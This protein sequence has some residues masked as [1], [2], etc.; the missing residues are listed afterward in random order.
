MG[1]R[2]S[3]ALPDFLQHRHGG[4]PVQ[5]SPYKWKQYK[6]GAKIRPAL[7]EIMEKEGVVGPLDGVKSIPSF[8]L[9]PGIIPISDW[10]GRSQS[11]PFP[12]ILDG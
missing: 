6:F 4:L 3:Q 7:I 1:Q 12:M 11:I 5:L 9:L 8:S 10:I 2:P